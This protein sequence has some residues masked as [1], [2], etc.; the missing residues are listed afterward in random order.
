MKTKVILLL[1]M[2]LIGQKGQ[3]QNPVNNKDSVPSGWKI[4]NNDRLGIT[5]QYPAT[6]T[7]YGKDADIINLSGNVRAT[8][9]HF[10]DTVS[11]T[12]LLVAYHF[13]PAGADLYKYAVSQYD[14]LNGKQI[15][16]AG[17]KAVETFTMINADGKGNVLKSPLRS[18]VINFLDKQQSGDIELQFK[19]FVTNENI[20]IAKFNYLLSSLKFIN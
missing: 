1:I 17:N 11:K 13:A 2:V 20:E 6:W 19:T 9:I 18:I 8:E 15:M 16:V 14:S 4:Y 12:T 7:E 10:S 3:G 5:F